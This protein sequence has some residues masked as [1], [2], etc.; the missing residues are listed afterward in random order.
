MKREETVV[1]ETIKGLQDAPVFIDP[2]GV[3]RYDRVKPWIV[4]N[5]IML[6]QHYE[7]VLEEM[8]NAR[9]R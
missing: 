9:L 1:R 4:E 6:L 7:A 5:A 3:Y 2:K 8:K